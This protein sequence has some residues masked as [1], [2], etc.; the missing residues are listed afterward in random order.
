MA[1]YGATERVRQFVAQQIFEP[2]RKRGEE[3]VTIHVGRLGKLLEERK[4]LQANRNPIIC[5]AVGSPIFARKNRAVLES[6][7]GPA[8][9]L[10]SSATFTFKL[11]PIESQPAQTEMRSG[12]QSEF[13]K[14]YGILQSTYKELG[15]ATAFHEAERESW[16]R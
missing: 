4:V 12:S 1:D 3:K 16:E 8:K 6:R 13:M 9:G 10:S 2:A 11:E 7:Q 14:L 15:G 5:G